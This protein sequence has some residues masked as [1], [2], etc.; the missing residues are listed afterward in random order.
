MVEIKK[1]LFD[2]AIKETSDMTVT[3]KNFYEVLRKREYDELD[4][5][6]LPIETKTLEKSKRSIR[7]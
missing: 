4:Y 7:Y 2:D 3:A 5:I 6:L 1:A